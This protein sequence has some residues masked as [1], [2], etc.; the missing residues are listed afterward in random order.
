MKAFVPDFAIVPR[1][2]TSSS[3]VMPMP[4]SSTVTVRL[5]RSGVTLM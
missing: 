4:E 2:F 5:S 1:W 3:R